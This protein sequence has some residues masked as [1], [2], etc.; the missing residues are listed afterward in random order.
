MA[1]LSTHKSKIATNHPPLSISDLLEV[2]EN[3]SKFMTETEKLLCHEIL[4][5]R[6]LLEAQKQILPKRKTKKQG[7][8][9]VRKNTGPVP[10]TI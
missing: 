5:L 2:Y 7:N 9:H 6:R 10:D 8:S 4:N 1:Y 3:F